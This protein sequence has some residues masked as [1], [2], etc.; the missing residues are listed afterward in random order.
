M[1][2]MDE[3]FLKDPSSDEHYKDESTKANLYL[4]GIVGAFIVLTFIA[5]LLNEGKH[6]IV[7]PILRKCHEDSKWVLQHD[8]M[9]NEEEEKYSV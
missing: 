9:E 2:I 3:E 7:L 5:Y 4:V 1:L 8:E 6:W